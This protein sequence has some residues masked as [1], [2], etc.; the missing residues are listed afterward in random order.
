[1]RDSY[2]ELDFTVTHRAGAHARYA[3]GDYIR[4]VNIGPIVL[5]IKHRLT[6]SSGKELEEIDNA[7][8]VCAMHKLISSSTGSDDLSIGFHRSNAIREN[9]LTDKETTKGNY[10]VRIYLKDLF[11][12]AEHHNNCSYWLG[13]KLTLQRNSDNDVLSHPAQ[14]NDA[15][16]LTLA[17]RVIIDDNSWYFPP[18]TPSISNQKLMLNKIASKT[19]TELTYIKRSY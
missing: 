3:D 13:Y 2:L 12:F 18:Y 15:A 11:G 16:N 5:F 10:H 1:M 14:A 4:L 7:L 8:V 6:S 19:P 17:G 9:E